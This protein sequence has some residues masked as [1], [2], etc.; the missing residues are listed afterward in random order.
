ME[1][2][3]IVQVLNSRHFIENYEPPHENIL[4]SIENKNIGSAGNFVIISGLPKAGKSTFLNAFISSNF[5]LLSS[6]L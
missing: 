4:L 5:K 3:E 2:H 6:S 1:Q